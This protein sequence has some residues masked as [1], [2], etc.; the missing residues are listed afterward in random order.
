[1]SLRAASGLA[2][3]TE[4]F[5]LRNLTRFMLLPGLTYRHAASHH[6]AASNAPRVPKYSDNVFIP[7]NGIARSLCVP[8]SRKPEPGAS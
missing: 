7:E 4:D 1:M 6:M 5:R 8:D 3:R 2:S